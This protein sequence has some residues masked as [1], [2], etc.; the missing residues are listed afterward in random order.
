MDIK[1]HRFKDR[2]GT[3][4][5]RIFCHMAG[6]RGALYKHELQRLRRMIYAP[7]A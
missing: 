7:V 4:S 6:V 1:N 5:D 3:F 2:I